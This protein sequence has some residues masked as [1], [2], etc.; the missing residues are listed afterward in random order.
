MNLEIEPTMM[1]LFLTHS[2]TPHRP[3]SRQDKLHS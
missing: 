1:L 2:N 3:D